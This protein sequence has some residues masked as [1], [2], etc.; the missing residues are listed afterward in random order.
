M[1]LAEKWA[2]EHQA[3]GPKF[4]SC[5]P[6]WVSTP[7]VDAASGDQKKYLE[8]MRSPWQGAEGI[9]WLMSTESANIKSGE[10]YLDRKVREKHIGGF[11]SKSTKNTEAEVTEM[12]S[13]MKKITNI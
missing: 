5:H 1:L 10:F 13:E 2:Q 3:A 6:G 12:L 9:A 7:A 11:F 4:V 8:P